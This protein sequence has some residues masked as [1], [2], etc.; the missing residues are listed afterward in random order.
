MRKFYQRFLRAY[1]K[2]WLNSCV[3]I[4]W[5]GR[6]DGSPWAITWNAQIKWLIIWRERLQACMI[7]IA[8]LTD[9][10]LTGYTTIMRG[11]PTYPWVT[12]WRI[13]DGGNHNTNHK[14]NASVYKKLPGG[15]VASTHLKLI[16]GKWF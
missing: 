11:E 1:C 4:K 5:G 12:L 10:W 14:Y 2:F 16:L 13:T 7:T 15:D 9:C 3:E 6:S 8:L